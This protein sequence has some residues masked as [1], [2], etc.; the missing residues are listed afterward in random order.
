MKF[1]LSSTYIDLKEIRQAAINYLEGIVGNISNAT[2]EIVAMECFNATEN[3]CKEECLRELS[4]CN[5]V[6]GIYGQRYGSVDKES[7]LSMTEIEFDYAV[8]HDIPILAFVMCEDAKGR[9]ELQKQFID[10]KVYARNTSCA[11]FSNAEEFIDRLNSSLKEYLKGL[12]G[13]SVDSLWDQV[14]ILNQAICAG[15]VTESGDCEMQ[16]LPYTPGQDMEAIN[17]VINS[18]GCLK[19]YIGSLSR[20]N[21]AVHSYA[22]M[23]QHYPEK[24]TSEIV[25]DLEKNV[26]ECSKDIL[27]NWLLINMGIYN[28]ATHI[29]LAATYLKLRSMQQRLL[30]E[31]WS[32]E[33]RRE[34]VETR[35]LYLETIHCSRHRD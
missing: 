18:A 24:R 29:I 19:G 11:K 16:M 15:L 22:Y 30:V 27:D 13:Y 4:S 20:E 10:S 25:A 23:V 6:I 5:L 33:L 7:N 9:D 35:K 12:D 32:E 21:E 3:T 2:G 34:V 31:T 1:F 8:E 28:H 26:Q 14:M 17:S